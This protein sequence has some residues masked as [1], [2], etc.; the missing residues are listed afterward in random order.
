MRFFLIYEVLLSIVFSACG[1]LERDDEVGSSSLVPL[2]VQDIFTNHCA[3]SGCHSGSSPKAGQNLS[4][5][6]AYNEIV[7]VNSSEQPALKRIHPGQPDNSYLVRK[8]EGTIGIDGDRMPQ[9][10][11]PYLTTAQIDT[12]RLWISNGAMS[13]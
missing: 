11:P 8:I 1:S 13:R 3:I 9:D 7:N 5:S 10:G 12:I 6:F 4:E 2:N